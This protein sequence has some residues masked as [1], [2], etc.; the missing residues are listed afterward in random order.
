MPMEPGFIGLGKMGMNMVERLRRNIV[1]AG[2]GGGRAVE[3]PKLERIRGWV[4]GSGEGRWTV[5]DAIDKDVAL[6]IIALSLF[7]RF[8]SPIDSEGQGS[9]SER[10]LAALRNEF[11]GHAVVENRE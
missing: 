8:R 1:V 11:G 6:P 5:L 10:L 2:V 4:A 3:D 9:F 7:T